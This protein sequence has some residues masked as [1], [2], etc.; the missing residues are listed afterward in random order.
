MCPERGGRLGPGVFLGPD[1]LLSEDGGPVAVAP[2][3][4]A[5]PYPA[6][7][8]EGAFPSPSV[9]RGIGVLRQPRAHL[10]TELLILGG[11]SKVHSGPPRNIGARSHPRGRGALRER[12][13]RTRSRTHHDAP[14]APTRSA[15]IDPARPLPS[16][17]PRRASASDPPPPSPAAPR[18]P[19]GRPGPALRMDGPEFPRLCPHRDLRPGDRVHLPGDALRGSP[20][21]QQVH[22]QRRHVL[23]F[24]DLG[25]RHRH[26]GR[27]PGYAPPAPR[28]SRSP[29]TCAGRA[30]RCG[31]GR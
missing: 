26:V 11:E 18:D 31:R 6:C 10:G 22:H 1:D 24:A 27:H 17:P 19:L 30:P 5:E 25:Q 9:Q 21:G 23:R 15:G 4:P 3:R 14:R 12:P 28:R 16:P 7:G 2:F 13:R 8:A 29:R 20:V